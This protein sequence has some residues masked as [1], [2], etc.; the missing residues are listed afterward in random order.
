MDITGLVHLV[1]VLLVLG[2]IAG[3]LWYL[4]SIAPYLNDAF[5]KIIQFVIIAVC[6]L[7]LIFAVLLPFIG[8]GVNTRPLLR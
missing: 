8:G 7:Y 6:V 4:V 2:I 3:L 5:K 1:V